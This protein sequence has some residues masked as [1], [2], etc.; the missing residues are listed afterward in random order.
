MIQRGTVLLEWTSP[1]NKNPPHTSDRCWKKE[2]QDWG[3]TF[4]RDKEW[5]WKSQMGRKWR[6]GTFCM[7]DV[8]L[9]PICAMMFLQGKRYSW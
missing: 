4:Q 1:D 5:D 2:H 3:R 9:L 6:L 7:S 8:N